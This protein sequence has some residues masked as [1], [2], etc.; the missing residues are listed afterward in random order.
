MHGMLAHSVTVG[1]FHLNCMYVCDVFSNDLTSI[2]SVTEWDMC[3]SQPIAT[4]QDT[5]E[6]GQ[7]SL[8]GLFSTTV[9]DAGF[10]QWK[11]VQGEINAMH[12]LTATTMAYLAFLH[13]TS[14]AFTT[15]VATLHP[16]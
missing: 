9:K 13:A 11:H 1:K 2:K 5:Y 12:K 14:R 4:L 10:A 16:H 7:V 15:T 8:A 3:K 6:T